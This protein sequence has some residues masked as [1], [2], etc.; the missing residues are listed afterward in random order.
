MTEHERRRVAVSLALGL[1]ISCSRGSQRQ[2][3]TLRP[4]IVVPPG[5]RGVT[6]YV[7]GGL[8][9]VKFHLSAP[10]PATAFLESVA[11]KLESLGSKPIATD[12]L[13]PTIPS[14]H[15]RGWTY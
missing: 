10:F 12:W 5:S 15:V 4:E 2:V 11:R 6:P 9:G 3:S 7:E 14:S 1:L 8:E 13:N